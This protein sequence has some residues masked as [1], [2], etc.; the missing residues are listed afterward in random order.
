MARELIGLQKYMKGE[1]I[2]VV[3]GAI[4]MLNYARRYKN[5]TTKKEE[6]ELLKNLIC[7]PKIKEVMAVINNAYRDF[8]NLAKSGKVTTEE[9]ELVKNQIESCNTMIN[10]AVNELKKEGR[11]Q[12]AKTNSKTRKLYSISANEE[13]NQLILN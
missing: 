6:W 10:D 8:N 9:Q 13:T 2:N 7:D 11:V 12:L 1:D 4:S 5:G 3:E